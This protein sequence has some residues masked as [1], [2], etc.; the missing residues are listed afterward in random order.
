MADWRAQLL[1]SLGAPLTKQNMKF[2]TAWQRAEGGHTNNSARFN[3]LNTTRDGAG[4]VGDINSV[5]VTA[6]DS[7][8]HGIAALRDTLLNGKYADIVAGLRQGNPYSAKPVAGLS[9]WVSG[10]PTANVKYAAKVLGMKIGPEDIKMRAGQAFQQGPAAVVRG[11]N[12]A[13]ALAFKQQ[14][15]AS[16]L[17]MSERTIAGDFNSNWQLLG[18]LQE[19]RRGL[20]QANQQVRTAETEARSYGGTAVPQGEGAAFNV[21][22]PVMQK[23]LQVADAQIG[24]PYVWGAESPSEGGFDCSGL[25]DWAY[26]QAGIDLPG[27]LTTYTAARMGVSV[28]GKAL[29]PGDW[30]ITNGG[31]HMV[32]YVGNG[33]VIAAPR[34]GERVQ[35][36]PVS[37][38]EGDIVDVRRVNVGRAARRGRAA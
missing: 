19:A 31:E 6:F 28:K 15:V 21:S 8:R 22:D 34:R 5:G 29:Q 1:R 2:L 10:S 33:Q 25:I 26:K 37:R 14:Q 20:L 9:T 35:Y 30:L 11:P 4:A 17:A 23:I 36:Q 18:Q 24:K 32:M 27:R 7:P 38:F 12:P 3:W 16:L 13:E